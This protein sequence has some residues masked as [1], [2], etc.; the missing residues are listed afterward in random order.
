[1]RSIHDQ[2]REINDAL[3]RGDDER[4]EIIVQ[5]LVEQLESTN[6]RGC[7]A[8]EVFG[9]WAK[10][11]QK[12]Q[13]YANEVSILERYLLF[14]GDEPSA[15]H[16]C[17]MFDWL[18]ESRDRLKWKYPHLGTC[19]LCGKTHR[20]LSRNEDGKVICSSCRSKHSPEVR[21]STID[22]QRCRAVGLPFPEK[23]TEFDLKALRATVLR[24]DLGLSDDASDDDVKERLAPKPKVF[25]TKVYG[26]SHKNLDGTSRQDIIECCYVGEILRL[27][28]EPENPHN[29][30]AVKVCR[31]NGDRL[32]Y[33][34]DHLVG[35]DKGIG[36][37]VAEDL[38]AGSSAHVA[39]S[40]ITGMKRPY[41]VNIQVT[42]G[43]PPFGEK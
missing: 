27:I 25:F 6:H 19:T 42:I 22:R 33:L 1:M 32:G 31:E 30:L 23:V 2:I 18:L 34:G 41:G 5:R 29:Y 39:I 11:A 8:A 15:A 37:C 21:I 17:H 24:R 26:V 16:E 3:K 20:R 9:K 40:D 13:D 35:N 28:R 10:I 14:I 4:A 12:R 43:V 7:I 36:W 38:D